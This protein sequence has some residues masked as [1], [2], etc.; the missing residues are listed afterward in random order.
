MKIVI[1]TQCREN[2]G[3]HDWDGNGACPQYWKFKG[4]DTYVV[5]NL[6]PTQ[7]LKIKETGIPTLKTLIE[8]KNDAF[9]EYV[10]DWSILDDDAV[11]GEAWESP[12]MLSWTDGRWTAGRVIENGEYGYMRQEI[13]RKVEAWDMLPQGNRENYNCYYILREDGRAVDTEGLQKVLVNS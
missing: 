6:S 12:L 2:Y 3:A 7:V 11:V 9:E 5:A 1:T 4:G 13:S 8:S 10:I